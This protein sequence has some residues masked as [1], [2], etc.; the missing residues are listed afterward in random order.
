MRMTPKKTITELNL[1]G[2]ML[3]ELHAQ[4]PVSEFNEMLHN[5]FSRVY[6]KEKGITPSRANRVLRGA[7]RLTEF[8]KGWE[9]IGKANVLTGLFKKGNELL[10]RYAQELMSQVGGSRAYKTAAN[11]IKR[12]IKLVQ[13]K[14]DIAEAIH[15]SRLTFDWY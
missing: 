10:L 2:S 6:A 14:F 4:L 9:Y 8:G 7:M 12:L 5:Q 1:I 13:A 11:E 15:V 3:L